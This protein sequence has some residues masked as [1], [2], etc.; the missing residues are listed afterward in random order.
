MCVAR[1][2]TDALALAEARH[3][4]NQIPQ[5]ILSE[6]CPTVRGINTNIHTTVPHARTVAI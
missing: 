4:G 6:N 5:R 3:A 1:A 2:D